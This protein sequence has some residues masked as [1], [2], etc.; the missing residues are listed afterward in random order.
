MQ[1]VTFVVFRG[2]STKY[3]ESFSL[4][5]ILFVYRQSDVAVNVI[6]RFLLLSLQMSNLILEG[7]HEIAQ[8]EFIYCDH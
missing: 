6:T 4:L 2:I 1:Y 3:Y 7:L 5:F 8:G